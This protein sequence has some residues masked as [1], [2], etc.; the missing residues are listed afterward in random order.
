MPYQKYKKGSKRRR[1]MSDGKKALKMVRKI[2]SGFEKKHFDLALTSGVADVNFTG[3]MYP[4]NEIPQGDTD[5]TREGDQ[6]FMT[7]LELGVRW[8]NEG[9][10]KTTMRCI[11]V[12]DKGDQ[13]QSTGIV[14][15][16]VTSATAVISRFH[17]DY[18][19]QFVVLVDKTWTMDQYNAVRTQTFKV[20]LNKKAQYIGG[21][22]T[23]F[24]KGCIAMMVISN[25]AASSGPSFWYYS[26][27]NFTDN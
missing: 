24:S 16:G 5:T 26:R 1:T 2:K 7:S 21:S 11:V 8:E 17:K 27:V 4:L 3:F 15:Q 23:N 20:P 9:T 14:L 18:R 25:A 10:E 13:V 6:I 22:T 12:Y 19:N